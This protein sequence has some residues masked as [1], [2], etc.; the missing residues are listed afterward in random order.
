MLE[1]LGGNKRVWQPIGMPF[2]AKQKCLVFKGLE[3]A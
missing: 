3:G 1:N 2:T